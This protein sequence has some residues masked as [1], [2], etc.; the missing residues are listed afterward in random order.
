VERMLQYL[1]FRGAGAWLSEGHTHG[2]AY[3]GRV[4]PLPAALRRAEVATSEKAY[5]PDVLGRALGDLLRTPPPIDVRHMRGP[6]VTVGERLDVLRGLL[7][8]ARSISFD[9]AV[10]GAD[11]V[12]VAVTVW[13]LLELYKRGE[14][15]WEQ[16]EPFGPI[17]VTAT[18]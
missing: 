5:D 16:D 11:R 17:T 12:T 14:A 15:A 8:R 1:R 13:A 3:L 6:R 7:R 18:A 10:E 2:Q 4:A 9:D